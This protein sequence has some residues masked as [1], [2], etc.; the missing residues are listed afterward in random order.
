MSMYSELLSG[1]CADMDPVHI[2]TSRDELV[3]ILLQCR[4]RLEGQGRGHGPDHGHVMAEDLALELDHDRMLLRLCAATG[5]E[6][7][8]TRFVNPLAERSRLDT[9]LRRA[10]VDFRTLDDHR[11][12]GVG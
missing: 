6:S 2:P 4:R 9:L 8:P 5:I 1:L 12:L 10:G 11:R 3:V 7:D